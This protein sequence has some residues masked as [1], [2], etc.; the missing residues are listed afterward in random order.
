MRALSPLIAALVLLCGSSALADTDSAL[1]TNPGAL[2]KIANQSM[3]GLTVEATATD[4][5][6][7]W[8]LY[9]QTDSFGS[10]TFKLAQW[11]KTCTLCI[12][13]RTVTL[14]FTPMTIAWSPK[15]GVTGRLLIPVAMTTQIKAFN[16]DTLTEDT[17]AG[18]NVDED[19]G[20]TFLAGKLLVDPMGAFAFAHMDR[21]VVAIDLPAW[22]VVW[23]LATSELDIPIT[24]LRYNN[25][26]KFLRDYNNRVTVYEFRYDS[27]GVLYHYTAGYHT[28]Y[29]IDPNT[30][31]TVYVNTTDCL[32]SLTTGGDGNMVFCS[33]NANANGI[34]AFDFSSTGNEKWDSLVWGGPIENTFLLGG[35]GASD[36]DVVYAYDSKLSVI[37]AFKTHKYDWQSG[38]PTYW[39]TATTPAPGT[40]NYSFGDF[41]DSVTASETS[42]AGVFVHTASSSSAQI[43]MLGPP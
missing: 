34:H 15:T 21:Q 6:R 38:G 18:V 7:V 37:S 26:L 25:Q 1:W 2:R 9:S 17:G 3:T 8:E 14:G 24:L 33:S 10:K 27:Y 42:P 19:G 22:R 32:G 39:V 5:N 11:P 41:T 35:N 43:F 20:R 30:G 31:N 36:A 28:A 4:G 12:P 23:T 40:A 16:P 13:T 29:S